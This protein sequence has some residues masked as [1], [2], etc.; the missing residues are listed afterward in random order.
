[1]ANILVTGATGQV[2]RELTGLLTARGHRIRVTSRSAPP[3]GTPEQDWVQVDWVTGA[4]LLTALDGI[5]TV[6]HLGTSSPKGERTM[7]DPLLAA[8]KRGRPHLLY[9]SIVGIDKIPMGYYR[10]KLEVET[11]LVESGLPHTILRATQFHSLLVS[12]LSGLA[13]SPIMVLP[14][15]LRFQPI[16]VPVVAGR[17]VELAEAAP[18]GRATDIGGPQVHGLADLARIYLTAAGKRRA[19]LQL[20]VPGKIMRALRDGANTTPDNALP[21]RTFADYCADLGKATRRESTD[22]NGADR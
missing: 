10:A 19:V 8:A 20:P 2:G 15:G 1:M 7:I 21:G 22:E 16:E 3:A 17:L 6:V 14:K 18:A 5:D 12:I 9:L 4:G 11:E 13:K